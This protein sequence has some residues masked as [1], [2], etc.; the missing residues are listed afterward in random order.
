M[1][2]LFSASCSFSAWQTRLTAA[3]L[4]GCALLGSF[5]ADLYGQDKKADEDKPVKE[6]AVKEGWKPLIKKDSLDGWEV[7]EFGGQGEVKV[8]GDQLSL[9]LGEPLTGITWKGKDFPKENFEIKLDAQRVTGS[10]FLCGLTFP[11]G[12][13]HASLI[14]GGWGGGLVGLSSVDGSDASE[15]STSTFRDFKNGQWYNFRVRVD[16]K[17]V[18]AWIDDER[19]FQQERQG[20]E[21]SVRA[22]VMSNRP[23]GFCVF[24][25]KVIVKNFEWRPLA[26]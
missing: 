2:R 8:V 6:P 3:L 5:S 19:V 15:N 9:A 12:D 24:Q 21:F 16:D 11:V 26:K 4:A 18:T 7:T 20:H 23:V 10:D 1:T 13:G 22:E 17:N 25:S 14:G